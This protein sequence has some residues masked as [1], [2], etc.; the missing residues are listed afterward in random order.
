MPY[1][2]T[3]FV[4]LKISPKAMW[5]FDGSKPDPSRDISEDDDESEAGWNDTDF[6]RYGLAPAQ[7]D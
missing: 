2:R 3:Y 6:D 5:G 1:D 4:T 7:P